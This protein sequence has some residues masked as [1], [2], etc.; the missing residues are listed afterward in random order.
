MLTRYTIEGNG[1][2]A[3]RLIE[4]KRGAWMQ[5][6]EVL[7]QAGCINC[8]VPLGAITYGFGPNTPPGAERKDVGPFCEACYELIHAHCGVKG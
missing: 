7:A 4:D 8:H 2:N 3:F 1:A 6:A 5:A